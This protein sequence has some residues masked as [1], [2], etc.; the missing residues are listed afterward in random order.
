[1]LKSLGLRHV[2]FDELLKETQLIRNRVGFASVRFLVLGF[3]CFSCCFSPCRT[4]FG[5]RV[6]NKL[7]SSKISTP[8][9]TYYVLIHGDRRA[10]GLVGTRAASYCTYSDHGQR[11]VS[12]GGN[13]LRVVCIHTVTVF[14]E[15]HLHWWEPASHSV[16]H[17]VTVFTENR[18]TWIG[19][20]RFLVALLLSF[21]V[22]VTPDLWWSHVSAS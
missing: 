6:F 8:F 5:Q 10:T 17:T 22:T 3:G 12:A 16:A 15:S 7:K 18:L 20:N 11:C 4:T 21:R 13:Q 14:T 19:G 9:V 2:L 1:M